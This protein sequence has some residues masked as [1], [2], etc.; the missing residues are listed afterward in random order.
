MV[1]PFGCGCTAGCDFCTAT[2]FTRQDLEKAWTYGAHEVYK[3]AK[4]TLT[5]EADGEMESLV[6]VINWSE[7]EE[8]LMD[9][10][11][12]CGEIEDD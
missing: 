12:I 2:A 4:N 7:L 3:K 9:A 5:V 8:Q 10:D 11:V 1:N 6:G